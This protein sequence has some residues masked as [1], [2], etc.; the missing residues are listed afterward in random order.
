MFTNVF[1]I[2]ETIIKYEKNWFSRGWLPEKDG[3]GA[4]TGKGVSK[5]CFLG[6]G[7]LKRAEGF[8]DFAETS[9]ETMG[10]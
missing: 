10:M 4:I 3:E 1:Y 6:G 5:K 9:K 7:C 8:L 2:I